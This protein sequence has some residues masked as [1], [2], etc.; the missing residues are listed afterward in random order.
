M[1]HVKRMS[2]SYP[3]RTVQVFFSFFFLIFYRVFGAFFF[4]GLHYSPVN[5]LSCYVSLNNIISLITFFYSTARA[6]RITIR[7]LFYFYFLFF[8]YFKTLLLCSVC[9]METRQVCTKAS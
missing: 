9:S 3:L 8:R 5:L 7:F 1:L 4:Y 2:H 6:E